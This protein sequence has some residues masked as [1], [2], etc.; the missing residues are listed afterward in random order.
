MVVTSGEDSCHIGLLLRNIGGLICRSFL[1][2]LSKNVIN[3]KSMLRIFISRK[4]SLT[5]SLA[6]GLLPNWD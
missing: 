5:L 4:G 3:A 2:N 6:F 1:R